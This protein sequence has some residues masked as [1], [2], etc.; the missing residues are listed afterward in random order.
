M[1]TGQFLEY[2]ACNRHFYMHT[3]LDEKLTKEKKSDCPDILR[4]G[5]LGDNLPLVPFTD[6]SPG[7]HFSKLPKTFWA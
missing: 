7:V 4:P 2:Y 1:Y 3:V 5:L 6:E